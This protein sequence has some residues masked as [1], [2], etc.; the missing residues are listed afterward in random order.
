MSVKFVLGNLQGIRIEEDLGV[1]GVPLQFGL[2]VFCIL[3]VYIFKFS[4][5]H[6]SDAFI[7]NVEILL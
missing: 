2:Y 5:R 4:I 3:Q 1:E 6:W 7:V